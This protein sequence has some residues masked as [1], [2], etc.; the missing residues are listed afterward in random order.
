MEQNFGSSSKTPAINE[1]IRAPQVMLVDADGTTNVVNTRQA[2]HTARDLGMDL[3][4]V[5]PMAKPPVCKIMDYS[6]EQYLKKRKSKDK[7]KL[8]KVLEDK[9]VRATA[10]Q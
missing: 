6:K 7:K 4:C 8:V 10:L 2:L 9:E 1:G 3:V 5:A